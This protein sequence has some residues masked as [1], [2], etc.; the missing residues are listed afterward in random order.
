MT[1]AMFAQLLIQF[2]D[3]AFDLAS[4]L[5][6]NWTSQTPLTLQDIE[7]A[8]KLGERSPRD[9]MVDA[10]TRAGIALDSPQAAA[11]LALVP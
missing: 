11:L 5:I 2:G 3:R 6:A 10:I 4:K 9:A 1:W 7:A 8:R